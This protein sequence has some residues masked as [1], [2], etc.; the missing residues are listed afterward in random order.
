[1]GLCCYSSLK[2]HYLLQLSY[3]QYGPSQPD[4]VTDVILENIEMIRINSTLQPNMKNGI[5]FKTWTG[6]ING[7]PP[8]GGGGA[9]GKVSNVTTRNIK[10]F[11]VDLPLHIYQTNGGHSADIPSKLTFENLQFL[12]WTGQS[13]GSKL[14]DIECSTSCDVLSFGGFEVT[15]PANQVPRFVCINAT[16]VTGLPAACSA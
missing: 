3:R 9:G 12:N 16:E 14:V 1:V 6:S 11:E 5:Y 7:S 13:T 15:P 4:F 10:L 8:T 2:T